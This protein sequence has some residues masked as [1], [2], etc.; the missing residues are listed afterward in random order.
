[1]SV[2]RGSAVLFISHDMVIAP[3]CIRALLE[4]AASDASIGVIRPV[5]PHM[6]CSRERQVT[7]PS[8]T[9]LREQRDVNA[10]SSFIARYHGTAV[11][12]PT[13]FI[14]DAMLIT[15]GAIE[16]IGVFDTRFF[17]FMADIDYGVRARR[18]GLRVVTA[19]GA[20]LYHEGSGTRKNTAKTAGVAA[21]ESLARRLKAEVETAWAAFRQKWDPALPDDFQ[22][23]TKEQMAR[24]IAAPPASQF[25]LREPPLAMDPSIWDVR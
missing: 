9:P 19:L 16:R 22:K 18:A 21:E 11:Q 6:D 2:A 23:I 13:F 10:F 15:R 3:A 4:T 24:L 17:G 5:S 8:T 14:G 12:E 20:W 25:E 7:V 1:M